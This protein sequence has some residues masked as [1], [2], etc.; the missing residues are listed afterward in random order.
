MVCALFPSII[1]IIIPTWIPHLGS[2]AINGHG[3]QHLIEQLQC[4][5]Q[6]HL[7][8]A[9]RLL[10]RL[11]RVIR[12]PALDKAQSQYAQ[13]TQIVHT[14]ASGSCDTCKEGTI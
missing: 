5:M 6:M 14:D 8:P 3:M 12:S 13:A 7:N 1:N 10:D 11:S 4:T 2:G 9:G